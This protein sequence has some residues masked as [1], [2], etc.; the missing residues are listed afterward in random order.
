MRTTGYY[1]A[2]GLT[3]GMRPTPWVK[4]LLIANT[5]AFVITAIVGLPLMSDLFAFQPAR[6]LVRPWGIVTY[7]FIHGG[8]WHLLMNLLMLFFFG[9][10]LEARWGSREFLRYYLI[11]GMGGVAFSLLFIPDA[12][13][14]ASAAIYGVMLAFAMLYPTVEVY[15]W[16]IF[17][18]QVRWLVAFLVGVSVLSAL[19]S[20]NDGVAHFAHLGGFIAGFLYLKTDWR[21]GEKVERARRAA[22]RRR[23]A[24]VP[25]R[26]E[27]EEGGER[28]GRGAPGSRRDE[29]ELLDAVDRVLDKISAE[30]MSALTPEERALLDEVSRRRRTN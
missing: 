12:V 22:K 14:G 19:G 2:G 13:I 9:P 21:L 27:S 17:P 3:F 4:R 24:I 30:G 8:P 5:V 1:G 20:P 16:G 6:L 18:I 28:R 29:R 10:A 26:D 15:I 11:C 25:G 23:L 7:M